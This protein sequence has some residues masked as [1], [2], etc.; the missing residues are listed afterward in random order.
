MADHKN[1]IKIGITGS[2]CSGKS[3]VGKAIE[4]YGVSCLD[5]ADIIGNIINSASDFSENAIAIFGDDILDKHK[6]L[7]VKKIL[8]LRPTHPD[9]QKFLDRM[10]YTKVRDEIKRFLFSPIG[11]A[12]R[13][14]QY[15]FLF[16][17]DIQHLCDEVWLVIADPEIQKQRLMSRDDLSEF[18]AEER[19]RGFCDT[20]DKESLCK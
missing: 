5:T 19:I 15:T 12:I 13:A 11:T 18:D 2:P 14:I 4:K 1:V 20:I 7:S 16:E 8:S 3:L 6:R 9:H 10:I 17:N